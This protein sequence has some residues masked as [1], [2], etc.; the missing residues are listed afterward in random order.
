MKKGMFFFVAAIVALP[1]GGAVL[2]WHS[3]IKREMA[4]YQKRIAEQSTQIEALED[5]IG[6]LN[7][8][9]D[10]LQATLD[11]LKII[12]STKVEEAEQLL[13]NIKVE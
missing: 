4:L 2:N 12:D 3:E 13:W 6:R 11:I 9:A 1:F 7:D 5:S 10:I 8:K